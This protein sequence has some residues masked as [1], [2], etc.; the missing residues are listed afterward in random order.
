MAPEIPREA[1]GSRA[2][3][4]RRLTF[5]SVL[6]G[7]CPLIPVPFVD[8][9]A[10]AQV[11]RRMLWEVAR[12]DGATLTPEGAKILA[13]DEDSG[14]PGCL[15]AVGW[16]FREVVGAILGKLFRTVFYFLTIRR[17]VRRSAETLHLGYLFDHVLSRKA[18]EKVRVV[19]T[20]EA[21]SI[22]QAVLTTLKEVDA[23][24]IYRTLFRD[25]R[26]SLSLLL[27]GAA[28]FRRFLP[29]RKKRKETDLAGQSEVFEREE[30]LLGGFTDRLA[31]DLW[32]NRA[33]FA[34]LES[35]FDKNLPR[36]AP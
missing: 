14:W 1:N 23:Q 16:V 19:T 10:L 33:Y 25:F 6:G 7:L 11:Q 31:A 29:R 24:P 21:R 18:A 26:R 8:D 4:F 9:W 35:T 12:R 17:S 3:T 30:A 5:F 22:R 13:G 36:A 15:G 32:G 2:A 34:V 28:L 27:Q 20:E